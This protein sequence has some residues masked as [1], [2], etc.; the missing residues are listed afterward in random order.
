MKDAVLEPTGSHEPEHAKH[1]R[2]AAIAAWIGSVLE[3]YDFF[4]YGTVSTLVFPAIFFPSG[5][6]AAA[7][8]ASLAT[9]GVGYA[10]RPLGSFLMGHIGDKVGR[11]TVMV[12]TLLL[13]G[14]AT[15]LVGCLP[16]FD[17]IGLWAPGLLV[18]LR[19]LQGISA[20]GEQ[21]GANSMSF[22]HAPYGRRGFF[23]SWTLSGSQAGQVLA[24]A[25]VLPLAGLLSQEQLL[26]WGWRIP[27][28]LSAVVVLVGYIVR[29]TLEETPAFQ[30]EAEHGEVPSVPLKVLF[31]DYRTPL[32]Q[33]FF[34]ALI[35][36]IG[37]TFA[38]FALSLATSKTYGIGVSTSLMLWVAVIANI[39]ATVII[40]V[41][42]SWSDRIGR[43]PIFL[44]GTIGCAVTVVLFLWSISTAD[45]TLIVI[46]GVLL[47]G[48]VYSLT[49]AV[50]PVTYAER[51]PTKVRLS[52]MAVGTQ[53][54]FALGGFAPLAAAAL[55][56]AGGT[57]LWLLPAAYAVA[58]CVIAT[59]SVATMKDNFRVHLND[60]GIPDAELG[61]SRPTTA[62][63]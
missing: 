45:T 37:S 31:R 21:A 34:A 26:A 13:M 39:V 15:F 62:V 25:V 42:A 33:V 40:P 59:I 8:I 2:K 41:Y 54:G 53:F 44:A 5:N 27:F 12:G 32:V 10:A 52:G 55:A 48:V 60:I 4:I 18:A 28:W 36:S 29:R 43:K 3:Y 35:S 19:I 17:Q 7:T 47:G 51:F 56:G 22:E 14:V 46:T 50:W 20:A 24:P 38:V 6:P 16:T 58:M 61:Q 63:S 49:N 23:T 57:P 11:K 30:D 1:P 9:F